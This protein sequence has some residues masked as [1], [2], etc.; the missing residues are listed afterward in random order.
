MI[1]RKRKPHSPNIKN[2]LFVILIAS[3]T[4]LILLFLTKSGNTV[5]KTKQTPLTVYPTTATYSGTFS[6][7]LVV[8]Y[9]AE[10]FV[11]KTMKIR[12]GT[13]V[14]F[15]NTIAN[16]MW[17]ASNPHPLHTG[18]KGFDQLKSTPKGGKYTYTFNT[19]GNYSYHNH[20]KPQNTGLIIVEK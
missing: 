17:V 1:H 15:V 5:K 4:M 13:S 11:P 12:V 3:V 16:D 7:Y 8:E 14:T 2:I 20:A 9:K 18:L 19:I 10:G 6:K